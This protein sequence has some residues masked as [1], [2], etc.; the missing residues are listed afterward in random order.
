[1][2]AEDAASFCAR[3]RDRLVGSLV[4]LVGD[5]GV[6]EELA[7]EALARAVERWRRVGRMASPEAWTYRTA[8]NLAHSW[9]RRG[10]IERGAHA[11]LAAPDTALP[12]TATAI[13][14]R[15]AVAALPPRQ[16]AVIVARYYLRLDV[17]ETARALGC[18]PGTVKAHTAKA[19]EHLRASGLLDEE[20]QA[21]P[22]LE[23]QPESTSG[24][25]E[26]R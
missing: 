13:A 25:G 19:M 18:S 21:E 17:A 12:D 8:Y 14:V 7:Q 23:A 10:R 11:R 6:A 26:D 5:R 9:F 16:R 22:T 1:M 20:T 24:R 2:N 4:L 3:M 15:A